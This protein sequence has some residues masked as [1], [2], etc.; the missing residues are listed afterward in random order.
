MSILGRATFAFS[1][2]LIVIVFGTTAVCS[3]IIVAVVPVVD[4]VIVV[5]EVAVDAI[6]VAV[7]L[8]NSVSSCSCSLVE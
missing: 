5:A 6:V 7:L 3:E 4:L 8:L 2:P 1:S